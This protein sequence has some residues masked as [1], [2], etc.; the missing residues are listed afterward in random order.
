MEL[1]KK[2]GDDAGNASTLD[3]SNTIKKENIKLGIYVADW[4]THLEIRQVDSV[5]PPTIVQKSSFLF[6]PKMRNSLHF[7]TDAVLSQKQY[8]YTNYI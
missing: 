1:V 2:D 4:Y 5:F 6:L 8:H 3:N 7:G